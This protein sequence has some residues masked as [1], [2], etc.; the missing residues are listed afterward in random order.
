[1]IY[2]NL[3]YGDPAALR[4]YAAGKPL[5]TIARQLRRH[6]RTVDDWMTGKRRMPWWV[7]ELLMLR[8]TD[9]STIAP[10]RIT[11]HPCKSNGRRRAMRGT[12]CKTEPHGAAAPAHF[13]IIAPPH[14]PP[15][16]LRG[17]FVGRSKAWPGK[18]PGFVRATTHQPLSS[19]QR[20][21]PAPARC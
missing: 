1:M 5:R 8:E 20:T 12:P 21:P 14:K 6:P 10:V 13:L 15:D 7:P 4:A 2:P 11:Q 19:P 17:G 3:R 9:L 18:E 16:L